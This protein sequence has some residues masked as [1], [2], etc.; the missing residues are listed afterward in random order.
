[1][2]PKII[3]QTWKTRCVPKEWRS[4]PE[5]LKRLHPDWKYVLSTDE[6]NLELVHK[7][8]PH[9]LEL[10][11]SLPKNIM[12]ADMVRYMWLYLHGGVYIDLDYEALKCF[13]PLFL[14]EADLYLVRSPNFNGFTNSFMAS[15]PRCEFWLRCLEE[16]E[17]QAKRIPF[18]MPEDYS[19]LWLTG[20]VML[21]K[22]AENYTK[23]FIIIPAELGHPCSVYHR[24]AGEC[25]HPEAYVKELKGSSWTGQGTQVLHFLIYHWK[26]LLL[27]LF[28]L[29]LVWM[30]NFS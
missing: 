27:L 20:P 22:V 13:D 2:I 12:R 4:S 24:A 16:I 28:V 18:W 23:P 6:D 1:M 11:Q 9:Y 15:K 26:V 17:R 3:F 30:W 19:V 29:L 5:S 7:H 25:Y 8:F 14:N 10:Y 21:T